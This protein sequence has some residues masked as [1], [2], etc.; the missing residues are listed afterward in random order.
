MTRLGFDRLIC[1]AKIC[2]KIL[3]YVL[4]G[5]SRVNEKK[6]GKWD[7]NRGLKMNKDDDDEEEK[8]KKVHVW[9]IHTYNAKVTLT[10]TQLLS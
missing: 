9:P 5:G 1:Q 7:R 2:G 8:K 6:T 10:L 3:H 4:N